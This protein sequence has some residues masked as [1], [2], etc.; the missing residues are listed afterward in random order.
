[1]TFFEQ[2]CWEG[3]IVGLI[4]G[5]VDEA[6]CRLVEAVLL[7]FEGM[8]EA[9]NYYEIHDCEKN[10]FSIG[11]TRGCSIVRPGK[12]IKRLSALY[13]WIELRLDK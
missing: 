3:V 13:I 8:N 5:G 12:Y 11:C 7:L 9:S 1:M 4:C 2:C 10:M 6:C